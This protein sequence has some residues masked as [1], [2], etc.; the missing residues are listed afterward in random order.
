MKKFIIIAVLQMTVL[1]LA[2]VSQCPAAAFKLPAGLEGQRARNVIYTQVLDGVKAGKFQALEDLAVDLRKGD[3]RFSDDR[4]QLTAFYQAFSESQHDDAGWLELIA[5]VER[6]RNAFPESVTAT[7]ALARAWTGYGWYARGHGYASTV[8]E[9]NMKLF[10]ERLS[11]AYDLLSQKPI[12][13]DCPGRYNLLLSL[14]GVLG[15]SEDRFWQVFKQAIEFEPDYFEF[16]LTAA[17]HLLPR[18]GGAPG[19]WLA[20]A[21]KASN[22]YP[23]P[24]GD[25]LYL[26]IVTRIQATGEFHDLQ[27]AGIS[28]ERLKSGF[29]E[30]NRRYPGSPT[31]ANRFALFA[32]LADDRQTVREVL[33]DATFPFDHEVWKGVVIDQCLAKNGLPS[34]ADRA[35]GQLA[36]HLEDLN[37]LVFREMLGKARKGET[38]AMAVVGEMFSRGEG[39]PQNDLQAYAWLVLSGENMALR[40]EIY[41]RLPLAQ[42]SEALL[43]VERLKK[44][45]AERKDGH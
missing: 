23:G 26:M 21:E 33:G 10:R 24:V 7:T 43:E 41:H 31:N 34:Q 29:R 19:E 1:L 8:S 16:Y 35:T 44:E 25:I 13:D 9:E 38:K 32:C 18:W 20:F 27:P 11:T 30:L 39:T 12:G 28:W 17:N 45:L 14:T 4:W 6:W 37:A 15:K 2:A 36:R 42:Q 5:G 3:A 40:E 22:Q